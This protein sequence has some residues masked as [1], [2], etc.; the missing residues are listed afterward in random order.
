MYYRMKK[1]FLIYFQIVVKLLLQCFRQSKILIKET[2]QRMIHIIVLTEQY[3]EIPS[4]DQEAMINCLRIAMAQIIIISYFQLTKFTNLHPISEIFQIS[5]IKEL[6]LLVGVRR[7][8]SYGLL[9]EFIQF[10]FCL[11]FELVVS[12][13]TVIITRVNIN[14]TVM[15]VYLA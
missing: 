2:L 7:P 11:C 9:S 4:I 5:F 3:S 12:K 10:C 13:E 14:K 15:T 6:S 8:S 1:K